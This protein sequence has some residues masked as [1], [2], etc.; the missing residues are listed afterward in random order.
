MV[1]SAFSSRRY[2][3]DR[4]ESLFQL[5]LVPHVKK[6]DRIKKSRRGPAKNKRDL[7]QVVIEHIKATVFHEIDA[8][9]PH[10]LFDLDPICVPVAQRRALFAHGLRVMRAPESH[11]QSVFEDPGAFG[12]QKDILLPDA[13]KIESSKY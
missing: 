6:T 11:G 3:L 4:P 8:G 12:A 10:D 1:C 7:S 13:F 9:K 5:T 2:S